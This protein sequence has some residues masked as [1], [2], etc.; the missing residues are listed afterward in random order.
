MLG[1]LLF[2][3]Y[4]N[5]ICEDVESNYFLYADDTSLLDIVDG[6]IASASKLEKDLEKV[7]AWCKNW[8][9]DMNPSKCETITF[10]TKHL[11]QI[12]PNLRLDNRPLRDVTSHTHLGLTLTSN[13]SW[14]Q[15][16]FGMHK[17]S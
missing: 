9:M 17:K 16:I 4:I 13:L 8:L 6:S 10:S 12:H 14:S 15:H 2:L 1:P 11:K 5:D 3:L 7:N